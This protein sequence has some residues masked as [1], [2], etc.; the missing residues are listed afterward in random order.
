MELLKTCLSLKDVSDICSPILVS[1]WNEEICQVT[2]A[3]TSSYQ[4]L[5][6]FISHL[7]TVGK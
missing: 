4:L 6:K 1:I 7:M 5:M 3:L 2:P